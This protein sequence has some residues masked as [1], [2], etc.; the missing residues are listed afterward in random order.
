MTSQGLLLLYS[1]FHPSD[2]KAKMQLDRLTCFLVLVCLF[3]LVL[4]SIYGGGGWR[5]KS[6]PAALEKKELSVLGGPPFLESYSCEIHGCE[7][8]TWLG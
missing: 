8:A 5:K 3:L 4:T 7:L 6:V 2:K 1:H